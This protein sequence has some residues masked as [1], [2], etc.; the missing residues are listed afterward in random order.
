[1]SDVQVYGE[2]GQRQLA[3]RVAAELAIGISLLGK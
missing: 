1:M 3:C 2:R